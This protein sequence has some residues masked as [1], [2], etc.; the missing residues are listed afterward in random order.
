MLMSLQYNQSEEPWP[1]SIHDTSAT[2]IPLRIGTGV[3]DRHEVNRKPDVC[4]T[5]KNLPPALS[6]VLVPFELTVTSIPE[7]K[8]R[9]DDKLL[10]L[11]SLQAIALLLQPTR[12][13]CF[14]V[15]ISSASLQH[16]NPVADV[17]VVTR[18]R[19]L[20]FRIQDV[21]GP[22]AGLPQLGALLLYLSRARPSSLGFIEGLSPIDSDF[23]YPVCDNLRL[24]VP[25]QSA[26]DSFDEV[27]LDFTNPLFVSKQPFSRA[28]TVV[29]VSGIKGSQAIA[30]HH[31][32]SCPPLTAKL[33]WLTAD[34]FLD[35]RPVEERVLEQVKK[36]DPRSYDNVAQMR[37]C[38]VLQPI[39][40]NDSVL[41]RTPVLIVMEGRGATM[42]QRPFESVRQV[43]DYLE[44]SWRSEFVLETALYVSWDAND[45]N[46][47]LCRIS[48]A[49]ASLT[50]TY[51]QAMF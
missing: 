49:S 7:P 18:S 31:A 41:S 15:H 4:M 1:T 34:H 11:L 14:G 48:G 21:F 35:G 43:L 30:R 3:S 25:S 8:D 39:L 47:Q 33:A 44:M 28:T 45:C 22:A 12:R 2:Y 51:R 32:T 29:D 23:A 16:Q 19:S 46:A 37:A 5:P 40:E 36:I 13:F 50:E 17:V 26:R 9:V 38:Y 20:W 10:Q 6:T 24:S 27:D 42:R